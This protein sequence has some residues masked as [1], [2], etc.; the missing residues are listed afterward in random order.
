MTFE[1]ELG[2]KVK[3]SITGLP[4]VVTARIEYISGC[5]QYEITP[6]KL[7]DGAPLPVHW[8]DEARVVV[9]K[10]PKAASKKDTHATRSGGSQSHSKP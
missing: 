4:G 9:L 10:P 6:T 3:D 2:S 7:K 8:I 5:L 1:Y